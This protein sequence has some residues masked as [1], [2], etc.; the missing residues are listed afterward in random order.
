MKFNFNR[1]KNVSKLI[2]ITGIIFITDFICT[3]IF[4]LAFVNKVNPIFNPILFG[5]LFIIGPLCFFSDEKMPLS[6]LCHLTVGLLLLFWPLFSIVGPRLYDLSIIEYI[7]LIISGILIVLGYVLII[8]SRKEKYFKKAYFG[9]VIS[10]L[11]SIG[12][13][14]MFCLK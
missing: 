5:Q 4:F 8:L 14:V 10:F 7:E 12:I 9:A 13:V 2:K 3:T 11:I 6:T 1:D